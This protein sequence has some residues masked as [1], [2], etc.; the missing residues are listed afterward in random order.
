MVD[1][2]FGVAVL[3]LHDD[4]FEAGA[5]HPQRQR[6]GAHVGHVG[7]ACAQG[8][9]D[10]VVVAGLDLLHLAAQHRAEILGQTVAGVGRFGV[11]FVGGVGDGEHAV[12]PAGVSC[13]GGGSSGGGRDI[14]LCRGGGSGAA[15]GQQAGGHQGGQGQGKQFPIA[16]HTILSLSVLSIFPA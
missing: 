1:G 16:F 4:G 5:L 6:L 7:A 3:R 2:L 11:G 15:A 13:F 12:F 8:F 9:D 10:G 14:R